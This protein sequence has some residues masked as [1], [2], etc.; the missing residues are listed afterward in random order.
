M[1]A[2]VRR[3]LSILSIMFV[4]DDDEKRKGANPPR[5]T[6]PHCHFAL[7]CYSTNSTSFARRLGWRS[8]FSALVSI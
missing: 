6:R 8:L 1:H 2:A 7:G 3:V 4:G 5:R